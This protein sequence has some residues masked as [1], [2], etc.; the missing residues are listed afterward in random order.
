MMDVGR[1]GRRGKDIEGGRDIDMER[2]VLEREKGK[3]ERGSGKREGERER[4]RY[5]ERVCM[6]GW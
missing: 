5:G 4:D 3:R 1:E 6:F 2:E